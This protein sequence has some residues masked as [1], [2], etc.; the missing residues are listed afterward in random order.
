MSSTPADDVIIWN[1]LSTAKEKNYHFE[2][3]AD[4][5]AT[6]AGWSFAGFSVCAPLL[7]LED[8]G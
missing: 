2:L 3:Q 4:P 1:E 6:V 5:L 7:F 8:F